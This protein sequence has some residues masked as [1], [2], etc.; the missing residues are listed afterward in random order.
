MAFAP[1]G[2]LFVA[3]QRG[4]LRVV[5]ANGQ[6]QETPFL[7]ARGSIGSSGERG[8]LGVALDPDFANNNYVYVYYTRKES[9]ATPAHNRVARYTASVDDQGN[10]VAEPGSWKLLLR[11]ANLRATNH[12]GGAIHFGSDGK[13]YVAVGENAREELAQSL[14]TRL[15]KILRIN[16]DGTIPTDN[17]FY[18]RAPAAPRPSGLGGSGTPTAST[19]SPER[20]RSSLTTS[21]RKPGRR[22]TRERPAPTTAGLASKAPRTTPTPRRLSSPTGTAS[23]RLRAARSPAA[24]S[25]THDAQLRARLRRRLLLRGLL[26]GLDPQAGFR[27]ERGDTL[28]VWF[29]R[30]SRGPQGGQ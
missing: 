20:A 27:D 29:R 26:H 28:Q 23:A 9:R 7:D 19:S 4:T 22:S 3:E 15:G 5:D 1:D 18:D 2:S 8:L 24:P 12:N 11:L 30:T 16:K 17:P 13:L 21:A 14:K 10:V 25:T 6:L